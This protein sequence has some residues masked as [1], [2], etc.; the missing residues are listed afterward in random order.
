MGVE[1]PGRLRCHKVAREGIEKLEGRLTV[2]GS[3]EESTTARNSDAMGESPHESEPEH[4]YDEPESWHYLPTGRPFVEPPMFSY[5][6]FIDEN[7]PCEK[8]ILL[9]FLERRDIEN[10]AALRD[11][12]T[13]DELL[14]CAMGMVKRHATTFRGRGPSLI[15]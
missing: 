3:R 11:H 8:R 15:L 1:E 5:D 12:I 10:K 13:E 9:L 6:K 14:C 4:S 2:E 7:V